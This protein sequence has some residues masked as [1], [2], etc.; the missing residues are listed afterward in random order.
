MALPRSDL[1]PIFLIISTYVSLPTY[2]RGKLRPLPKRC[3]SAT[4]D[5]RGWR[6]WT[7]PTGTMGM[8][9]T[10]VAVATSAAR[11]RS[12]ATSLGQVRGRAI[13]PPNTYRS[14]FGNVSR[15]TRR[16][17]GGVGARK[18]SKGRGMNR[19]RC[20]CCLV[21]MHRRRIGWVRRP[22]SAWRYYRTLATM[23]TN[24]RR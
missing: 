1:L 18:T 5:S 6:H 4:V 9:K 19:C 10:G 15:R 2:R 20:R 13:H 3:A 16:S 17:G 14:A 22:F 12:H 11:T 24:R 8:T 23:T 7:L 21:I